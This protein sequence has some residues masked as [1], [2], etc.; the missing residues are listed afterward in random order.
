MDH[1]KKIRLLSINTGK[2]GATYVIDFDRVGPM[3]IKAGLGKI[4]TSSSRLKL[5]VNGS[6]VG[7]VLRKFYSIEITVSQPVACISSS[8]ISRHTFKFVYNYSR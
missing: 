1:I 3:A 8:A 5:L 4:L 7:H 2:P 6:E